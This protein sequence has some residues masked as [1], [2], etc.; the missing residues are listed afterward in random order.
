M[1]LQIKRLGDMNGIFAHSQADVIHLAGLC[2]PQSLQSCP[3][4][5]DPMDCSS[6]GSSILGIL[7]G[8]NTGVSCHVLVAMPSSRIF[9]IQGSNPTLWGEM[10]NSDRKA[11]QLHSTQFDAIVDVQSLNCV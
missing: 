8:K 2:C 7:S 9:P 1:G 3:T 6:L 11:L 5:F 4:L 10:G